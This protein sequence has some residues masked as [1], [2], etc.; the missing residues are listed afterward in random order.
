M[1]GS[2]GTISGQVR[3]DVA[4]AIAAF[5]AVRSSSAATSGAMTAAGSRMQAFGKVS[6]VAGLGLVGAFG[7]AVK[8]AAAFEK[9]MDYF[10]AVNNATAKEMEAVRQKALEL[11]RTSQY[12]AGQ[13]ADAFVE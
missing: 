13:I 5:A 12:S 10:G 1:A 11:G 2:L 3:L 4:Q 6:M 8:A 7:V 9:K